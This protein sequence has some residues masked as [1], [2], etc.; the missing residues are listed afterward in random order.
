MWGLDLLRKGLAWK[1]G[2]GETITVFGHQWI[3]G[4]VNP[5]L[6]A[7]QPMGV[8]NFKVRE[9]IDWSTRTWR[10]PLL[11]QLFP[12]D[13]V[14]KILSIYVP[15]ENLGDEC[16][17]KFTG[18][19]KFSVKSAYFAAIT[20]AFGLRVV[21]DSVSNWGKIWGLQLPTKFSL[22]LVL[23]SGFISSKAGEGC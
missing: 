1:V 2:N 11:N 14:Q 7:G 8:C 5:Y 19:G 10:E 22:F 16:F 9:L 15:R 20:S 18:D 23:A 6:V 3:P 17:W 13:L 12:E 21:N 4:D